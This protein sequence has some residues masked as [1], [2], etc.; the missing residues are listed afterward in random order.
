MR[1]HRRGAPAFHVGSSLKAIFSDLSRFLE[2]R[3]GRRR[4]D[5]LSRPGFFAGCRLPFRKE[6][7]LSGPLGDC[8]YWGR[9][10]VRYSGISIPRFP[11]F[12]F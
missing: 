4:V 3:P 12:R 5:N 6:Y 9:F 11:I 2:S 10:E 8:G 1:R 7:T